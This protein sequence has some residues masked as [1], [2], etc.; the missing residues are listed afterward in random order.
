[1][2][3]P[4]YG[5]RV[6]LN[7]KQQGNKFGPQSKNSKAPFITIIDQNFDFLPRLFTI[8]TNNAS[9]KFNVDL[10]K[11]ASRTISKQL[12]ADPNNLEYQLEFKDDK[13]TM[14][15]FEDIFRGLS[16]TFE[17]DELLPAR[18]IVQQLNIDNCP[19]FFKANLT[20]NFYTIP[21]QIEI[22]IERLSLLT[23]LSTNFQKTFTIKTAKKDFQ[24]IEIG[25]LSSKVIRDLKMEDPSLNEYTYNF[26]DEGNN[27]FE[28]ICNLFNFEKINITIMNMDS[29]KT[30]S[31]ELQ[32]EPIINSIDTFINSYENSVQLIDDKK[33][34]IETIDEIFHLL[35]NIQSLTVESVKKSILHSIWVKTEENVQELAACIFQAVRVSYKL[36]PFLIELII[37]LNDSANDKNKLNTL[38]PYLINQLKFDFSKTPF[39]SSFYFKLAQKGIVD[40]DEALRNAMKVLMNNKNEAKPKKYKNRDIVN[41]LLWFLPELFEKNKSNNDFFN[42]QIDMINATFFKKFFP[43]NVEEY[44]KIR[45]TGMPIDEISRSIFIDDV[46]TLQSIIS[47]RG[48][49]MNDFKIQPTPFDVFEFGCGISLINYSVMNGS[50]KCFKY[51]LLNHAQMDNLTFVLSIYGGNSEIIRAVDQNDP[52]MYNSNTAQF[53]NFNNGLQQFFSFSDLRNSAYIVYNNR[54]YSNIVAPAIMNHRN[55]LFDWIFENKRDI[56]SS[57]SML[58]IAYIAV[59]NGNAHALTQC[60]DVGLEANSSNANFVMSLFNEACRDGFYRILQLLVSLFHENINN[61]YI[62]PDL[63]FY[64]GNILIYN[65]MKE[66]VQSFFNSLNFNSN[67]VYQIVNSLKRNHNKLVM[68]FID[69]GD[70]MVNNSN[71]FQ[72]LFS[73]VIKNKNII[74]FNFL[75]DKY[76]FE[77]ISNLYC[78]IGNDTFNIFFILNKSCSVGFFEA[79]KEVT[80]FILS[81]N[82]MSDFTSPFYCAVCA[83]QKEIY[84]YLLEK[85]VVISIKQSDPSLYAITQID[86][87]VC[88]KLLDKVEPDLK[89]DVLR[90]VF[91]LAVFNG[92]KELVEFLLDKDRLKCNTLIDAVHSSNIDIVNMILSLKSDPTFI[93]MIDKD[94]TALNIAVR[95]NNTE[96]VKRLLSLPGINTTY[97]DFDDCTPL[98]TAIT[99]FNIEMID[100]FIDFYGDQIQSQIWQIN[101]SILKILSVLS[102][103]EEKPKSSKSHRHDDDEYDE[104]NDDNDDE[105]GLPKVSL[106]DTKSTFIINKD[107]VFKT[108]SKLAQIENVDLN[109]HFSSYTLLSYACEVDELDLFNSLL[110]SNKVNVNTYSPLTGNTPLMVAIENNNNQIAQFLIDHSQ[111]DINHRNYKGQTALTFAVSKEN[112]GI[113]NSLV[114]SEKFD[115][116]LSS[117]IDAYFISNNKIT[118]LLLNVKEFDVNVNIKIQHYIDLYEND[119]TADNNNVNQQPNIFNTYDFSYFLKIPF[120]T[121]L[122]K[123][124][125]DLQNDLIDSI[126]SHPS[127]DRNKSRYIDAIFASVYM[128]EI[129]I[130]R[131]LL[132]LFGDDVNIIGNSGES[133]LCFSIYMRTSAITTEIL[134]NNTFDE[135]KSQILEAFFIAG[136]FNLTSRNASNIKNLKAN[137]PFPQFGTPRMGLPNHDI[138]IVPPAPPGP[139]GGPIGAP[140]GL[141]G[142]WG[143]PPFPGGIVGNAALIN[144]MGELCDFDETHEN[145]IK[146]NEYLPSGKTFFTSISWSCQNI[147]AVVNF[148]VGRGADP[149]LPDMNGVYPVEYC[150][151][152]GNQDFMT[153][154][155]HLHNIDLSVKSSG[156]CISSLKGDTILHTLI[157]LNNIAMFNTVLGLNDLHII[158]EENVNGDTPLLMACKSTRFN[159]IMALF[160]KDDLDYKHRNKEGKDALDI[161]NGASGILKGQFKSSRNFFWGGGFNNN[162]I[163]LDAKDIEDEEKREYYQKVSSFF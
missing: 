101:N 160:S 43:S 91:Q 84:E 77:R 25:A 35:H 57:I 125:L 112:D 111:T 22:E 13:F 9:Y 162:Q 44:K 68:H 75:R 55:D 94:G 135:K 1:M 90:E 148:L 69:S 110:K 117:L 146:F 122:I 116:K 12:E 48:I 50:L 76:T 97:Y 59:Q 5:N 11:D 16:A 92:N 141:A 63:L 87:D 71:S 51:L 155:M 46:D 143:A 40:M 130:F 49:D 62:Q 109:C 85:N 150:F 134:N 38:L 163:Q 29:L 54:Y 158:N 79:V 23:F 126:V 17:F 123:A 58:D 15:K 6:F 105:R 21:S 80:E 96:I 100:I 127:F 34:I 136:C 41:V 26:D 86:N 88:M 154:M 102:K 53:G 118:K 137:F 36:Q 128:N 82:P 115:H 98:M 149:N 45:D 14:K 95:N 60:I 19:V 124:V 157:Q 104:E 78:S 18:Q 81:K 47:K 31:E 138:N 133:L 20:N 10:L 103:S 8:K 61:V 83:K 39:Y 28:L 139:I 7:Q 161:L 37:S 72:M 156:N 89:D 4:N 56:V 108:I 119:Q 74:L 27:D 99:N 132:T 66:R 147:G 131:K 144:Q 140:I 106:I 93:N 113:V 145:L 30:F 151:Q 142:G 121:P 64:S 2:F 107:K 24:C 33:V 114:N 70:I 152:M 73:S 153:S 129:D 52:P 120:I 67:N 42:L 65:L 32:I 159:F 3:Q